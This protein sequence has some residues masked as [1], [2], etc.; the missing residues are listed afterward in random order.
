MLGTSKTEFDLK[1]TG[2]GTVT[3]VVTVKFPNA[4]DPRVTTYK[5]EVE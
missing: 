1:L 4:V 5:F 3:A 2:K